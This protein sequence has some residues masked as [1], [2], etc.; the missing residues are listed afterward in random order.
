MQHSFSFCPFE[1]SIGMKIR[2]SKH[3]FLSFFSLGNGGDR[4][5]R[6]LSLFATPRREK[7]LI[8]FFLYSGLFRADFFFFLFP[9]CPGRHFLHFFFFF[10]RNTGCRTTRALFSPRRASH[11]AIHFFLFADTGGE[12]ESFFFPSTSL[13]SLRPIR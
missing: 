1:F 9:P 4:P 10:Y 8:L 3:V 13:P 5:E 11:Q 7:D 6:N 2:R 12:D